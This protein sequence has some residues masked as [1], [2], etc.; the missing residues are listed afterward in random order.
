MNGVLHLSIEIGS[1][2]NLANEHLKCPASVRQFTDRPRLTTDRIAEIIRA[3]QDLGFTGFVGFHFFNEPTMY[4]D[5]IAEVMDRVP[6]ARYMLITNGYGPVDK[7]FSW[8]YHSP[9]GTEPY[10]FDDRIHNYDEPPVRRASCWR[11]RVECAIDYTGMVALC[12]QDW[13]L[14]S[15]CGDIASGDVHEALMVWSAKSRAVTL[16]SMPNA[17]SLCKGGQ[18]KAEY[19]RILA[20]SGY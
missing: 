13:R 10:P 12:C 3:A 11:P 9:Y 19:E 8:V 15:H 6:D 5:R 1:R 7:R 17:C 2:C 18:D 4:A 14:T 16:G 20:N